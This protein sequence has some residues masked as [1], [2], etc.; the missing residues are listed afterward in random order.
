VIGYARSLGN[1]V[2]FRLSMR[3]NVT[4]YHIGMYVHAVL[5]VYCI[6]MLNKSTE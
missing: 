5:L 2:G 1:L 3:I 4:P 6:H